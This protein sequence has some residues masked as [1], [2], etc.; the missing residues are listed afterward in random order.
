M[1][2]YK[3]TAN[4]QRREVTVDPSRPLGFARHSE[5]NLQLSCRSLMQA[6]AGV[7]GGLL[8]SLCGNVPAL[9]EA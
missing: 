3:I 2:V 9:G 7:A 1:V 4:G 5:Q 8:I 6:S